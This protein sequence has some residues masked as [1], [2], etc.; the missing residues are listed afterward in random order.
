MCRSTVA[1]LYIVHDTNAQ[2]LQMSHL[3]WNLCTKKN[4]DNTFHPWANLRATLPF[5]SIYRTHEYWD[6]SVVHTHGLLVDKV[7]C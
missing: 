4:I 7:E 1:T 5:F 3:V 2:L 6:A